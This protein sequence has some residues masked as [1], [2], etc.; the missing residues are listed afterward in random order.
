MSVV[1]RGTKAAG[2]TAFVDGTTILAA[3]HNYDLDTLYTALSGG[4]DTNNLS[5]T[6]GITNGQL[7]EIAVTK[8]SDYSSTAAV[9]LTS[10]DAG[11]TGTLYAGTTTLPTDLSD[12]LERLRYRLLANNHLISTIYKNSGGTN[13]AIGWVEAP[14]VGPQLLANNGFELKSSATAGVAPDGWTLVGTPTSLTVTAA[15]SAGKSVGLHKRSL[16]FTSAAANDGISQTVYGLKA[17]TKYLI[18]LA[19]VRTDATVNLTVTGGLG[20]GDYQN[21]SITDSSNTTMAYMQGIVQTDTT[22]T[23]LTVKVLNT[24]AGGAK[25]CALYQIWMY[26]VR[27]QTPIGTPSIPLQVANYSTVNDIIAGG[28]AATWTNISALTLSQQVPTMGYRMVFSVVLSFKSAPVT[29][30]IRDF[31]YGFRIQQ[32]IGAAAAATVEGPYSWIANQQSN[33]EVVGG[34]MRMEWVVENPTPGSLYTF[35]VD[36][37]VNNATVASDSGQLWMN[38]PIGTASTVAS[39]SR[40]RL[41]VERM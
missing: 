38:P 36:V 28:G 40:S 22:P 34:N 19:Y 37:L 14:I 18:G 3:E 32:K 8:V 10:V 23:D 41:V 2:G 15:S 27:D 26:E 20:S 5:P 4:L 25:V 35:T 9:S 12:E 11:S 33:Q 24:L 30:S 31:N 29:A 13:T 21:F 16:V 7:E 1:T 17:S 39:T 6:A